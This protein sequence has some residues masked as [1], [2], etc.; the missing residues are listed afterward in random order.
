MNF[1]I[2]LGVKKGN[3]LSQALFILVVEVPP[4]ALSNLFFNSDFRGIRLPNWSKHINPLCYLD[5]TI[6]FVDTDRSSIQLIT[7]TRENYEK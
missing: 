7:K 1:L 6:I 5:N 4:R 3:P 2:R